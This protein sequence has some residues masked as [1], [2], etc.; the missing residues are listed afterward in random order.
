[1]GP[2]CF[3]GQSGTNSTFFHLSVSTHAFSPPEHQLGQLLVLLPPPSRGQL[4]PEPLEVETGL[5]DRVPLV[6]FSELW[7]VSSLLVHLMY[8]GHFMSVHFQ[9]ML[10]DITR[11]I[12]EVLYPHNSELNKVI[13][14]DKGCTFLCVFGL[15]GEKLHHEN[16]HALQSAIQIFQSCSTMLKDVEEVSVAVINVAVTP[17]FCGVIGHPERHEYTG[18]RHVSE[19]QEAGMGE[20]LPSSWSVQNMLPE[21]DVWCPAQTGA[22]GDN[23]EPTGSA[24]S[25]YLHSQQWQ[26]QPQLSSTS[27]TSAEVVD[28]HS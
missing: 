25:L 16:S 4:C 18:T 23:L 26:P 21:P 24:M 28:D 3:R 20:N 19:V 2:G 27:P 13:L 1:M 10:H 5:D 11:I 14:F 17:T 12:L 15:T 8:L 7:P 9:E 6:L 22:A